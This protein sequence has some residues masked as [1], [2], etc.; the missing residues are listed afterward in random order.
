MKSEEAHLR[1]N[2]DRLLK[3]HIRYKLGYFFRLII[4]CIFPMALTLSTND[5]TIVY[6]NFISCWLN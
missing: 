2:Q 6:F 3:V 1:T 4:D 5:I